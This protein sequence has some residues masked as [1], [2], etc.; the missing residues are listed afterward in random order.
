LHQRQARLI[1]ALRL[2]LALILVTTTTY[3][4]FQYASFKL[5]GPL[6][7]ATFTTALMA[8]FMTVQITKSPTNAA[9]NLKT[10]AHQF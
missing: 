7:T 6:T 10:I 5:N 1:A 3:T 9:Q 4:H 8:V 2:F